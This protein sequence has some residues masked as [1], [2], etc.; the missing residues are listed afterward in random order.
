MR[1][2]RTLL[3]PGLLALAPAAAAD[4]FDVDKDHSVLAF[5]IDHLGY[6]LVR[7]VFREFEAEIDLD[8]DDIEATSLVVRIDAASVD[9]FS[10][11]RD[12]HLR[13]FP[14][15]LG[16]A[17]NPLITFR[18]TDVRQTS[19]E[20]AVVTGD[21][22]MRGITL[23]VSFDLRLN[24]RGANPL[25]GGREWFGFSGAGSLDRTEFGMDFAAPAVGAEVAFTI[26][27]IIYPR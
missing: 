18:S 22:T 5:S 7:G 12:Q 14:E 9:T 20:T 3:L 10:A 13:E 17:A 15:L 27:T 6:N 19:A 24:Q 23:P 16:V 4:P 26:D 11:T 25:S 21:L 1:A 2:L 8:P